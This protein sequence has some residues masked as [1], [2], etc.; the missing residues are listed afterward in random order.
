MFREISS[1]RGIK[2]NK[3]FCHETIHTVGRIFNLRNE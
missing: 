1:K 3:E 2:G